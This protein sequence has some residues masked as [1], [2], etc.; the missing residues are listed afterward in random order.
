MPPVYCVIPARYGAQRFPGKPLAYLLGKPL[1]QWVWEAALRI[2]GV[3][4]VLVATDDVRIQRAV[5]EFGGR[6]VMT[7]PECPSGTDRVAAAL[8]G[9]DF[10]AAINVQGDEPLM[11]PDT[12]S[13]ALQALLDDPECAVGTACVPILD[14]EVFE[15]PTVVKVV[16]GRD[17]VALYFSR[18]PIPS[19][20]RLAAETTSKPGFVWGYKHLGIY[21]YRP[22]PLRAF[23]TMKPSRLE[24]VESLEQLRFLEAGYR[25]R[26]VDT[27]HDATGVDT[28]EDLERAA[29]ILQRRINTPQ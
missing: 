28:P 6:V 5:T 17:D 11:H 24:T 29:E 22:D 1:V 7:S 25:I 3:D 4:E 19:P 21:V 16:R 8:E 10:T 20:A 23:I 26:C 18:S 2:H 27:P 13:R 15:R 12:A 9:R 14:R